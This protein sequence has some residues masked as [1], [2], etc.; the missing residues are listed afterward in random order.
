MGT[1]VVGDIFQLRQSLLLSVRVQGLN[2]ISIFT[3]SSEA[4]DR[5]LHQYSNLMR[6]L[7]GGLLIMIST[8]ALFE[9]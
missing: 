7:R 5:R 4:S 9:S 1:Q 8:L 6:R 2:H 3:G